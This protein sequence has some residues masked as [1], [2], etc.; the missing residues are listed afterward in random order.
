M[1]RF[2]AND[3]AIN[4]AMSYSLSSGGQVALVQPKTRYVYGVFWVVKFVTELSI[5]TIGI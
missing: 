4:F 5:G 1:D 2:E 3:L